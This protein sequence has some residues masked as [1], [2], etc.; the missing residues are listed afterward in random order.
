L[1]GV[2]FCI[3]EFAKSVEHQKMKMK[4][5]MEKTGDFCKKKYDILIEI[6]DKSNLSDV[7]KKSMI[8]YSLF[9]KTLQRK[10]EEK[11]N[12]L[13]KKNVDEELKNYSDHPKLI[14]ELK[15][16]FLRKH[17]ESIND[18]TEAETQ[19]HFIHEALKFGSNYMNFARLKFENDIQEIEKINYKKDCEEYI[20][21]II[22]EFKQ[23]QLWVIE[24]P[25]KEKLLF[26]ET[27]ISICDEIKSQI[28][29]IENESDF[30]AIKNNVKELLNTNIQLKEILDN[31]KITN[32]YSVKQNSLKS[33]EIC[34]FPCKGCGT[35]CSLKKGH[36]NDHEYFIHVP[37]I[38][39][40]NLYFSLLT[41]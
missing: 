29:E 30:E 38:F 5:K 17:F 6:L 32:K 19:K 4:I 9:S 31:L 26:M 10:M 16:K 27:D 34:G 22:E 28:K 12:E 39:R 15:K 7:N 18:M 21:T 13:F 11:I 37:A 2:Y 25:F 41:N 20:N 23:N 33:L 40:G 14:K 35:P 24:K 8:I 3:S 36:E 1:F